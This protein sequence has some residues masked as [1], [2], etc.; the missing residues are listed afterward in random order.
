MITLSSVVNK[1]AIGDSIIRDARFQAIK[2]RHEIA[3]F[4][5]Q[6]CRMNDSKWLVKAYSPEMIFNRGINQV[7]ARGRSYIRFTEGT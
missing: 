2:G 5:A 1:V 7:L 6:S 3:Y 4:L